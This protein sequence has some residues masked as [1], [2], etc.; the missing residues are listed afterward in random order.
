VALGAVSV[1]DADRE[2]ARA[3]ARRDVALY[4][5]V[6]ARLDPTLSIDPEQMQRIDGH[7]KRGEPEQAAAL[8]GDDL[9]D[10]FALAGN[11]ADLI[12]H[13]EA[14]FA[15]GANRIEF[16]TPHGL[17]PPEGIRLLGEKVLPAL[18]T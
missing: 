4:L 10:R 5:P 11:P 9:L 2:A 18:R 7:V 16:G 17:T 3:R 1:V 6:V 12:A 8:I 15:A 14:L 13:S